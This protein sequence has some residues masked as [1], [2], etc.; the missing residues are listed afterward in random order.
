[1]T[2]HYH[3]FTIATN[4]RGLLTY[5]HELLYIHSV[6]EVSLLFNWTDL[7]V[8]EH[9]WSSAPLRLYIHILHL[10]APWPSGI[11]AAWTFE[12]QPAGISVW[13]IVWFHI[14]I[15]RHVDGLLW[16]NIHPSVQVFRFGEHCEKLPPNMYCPSSLQLR[17]RIVTW[18]P[19]LT[20]VTLYKWLVGEIRSLSL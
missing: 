8:C 18:Y 10:S 15:T 11:V 9:V 13:L 12:Q 17:K 20:G 3:F 4:I 16:Y 2:Y 7:V 6:V 14:S 19:D 5:V 1:M